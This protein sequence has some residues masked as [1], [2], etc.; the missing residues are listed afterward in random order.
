MHIRRKNA[1]GI[2]WGSSKRIEMG[3]SSSTDPVSS[4]TGP[5][6]NPEDRYEKLTTA[7]LQRSATLILD[8]T[9]YSLMF[10]AFVS[11]TDERCR[12]SLSRG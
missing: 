2:G 7:L 1:I 3:R 10:F 9:W 5:A 11:V 4:V 8:E 12:G 6:S